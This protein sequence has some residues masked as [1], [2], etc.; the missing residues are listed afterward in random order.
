[1]GSRRLFTVKIQRMRTLLI[2]FAAVLLVLPQG[3]GGQSTWG[4]Y[5]SKPT[6]GTAGGG[7]QYTCVFCGSEPT[8]GPV[9]AGQSI[10]R[11]DKIL[12]NT[13]QCP[14]TRQC[15]CSDGR[16]VRAIGRGLGARCP[17]C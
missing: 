4:L 5:G 14:S 9:V 6:S 11:P 1:M 10:R 15:R 12:Y 17:K 2:I 8:S 16:C 7:G 3:G 13:Q